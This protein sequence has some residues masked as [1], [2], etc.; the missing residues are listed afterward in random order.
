MKTYVFVTID[1]TSQFIEGCEF[2]FGVYQTADESVAEILR[3]KRMVKEITEDLEPKKE[4][5]PDPEP[6]PEIIKVTNSAKK[7]GK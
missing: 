7:R 2:K 3:N 4:L 5:T 6:E 1:Q